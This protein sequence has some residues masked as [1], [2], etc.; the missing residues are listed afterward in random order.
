MHLNND[1]FDKVE[2][3][4]T[5]SDF[6]KDKKAISSLEKSEVCPLS[7]FELSLVEDISLFV[8]RMNEFPEILQLYLSIN[9]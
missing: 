9:L 5:F 4:S 7:W 6:T 3:C 1:P 2:F 8:V